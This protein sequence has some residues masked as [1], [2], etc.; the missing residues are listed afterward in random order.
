VIRENSFQ[1][2]MKLFE[3]WEEYSDEDYK[4]DLKDE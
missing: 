4:E 2:T 3:D 1:T